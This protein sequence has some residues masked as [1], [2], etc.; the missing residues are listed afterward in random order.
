MSF[1][2]I[3]NI[4][5]PGVAGKPAGT[6]GE[7]KW[8]SLDRLM[9]DPRYQREVREQGKAHI[10]KIATSFDW[11]HFTPVIAAPITADSFAVIDGQH[12]LAAAKAIGLKEAPC[13]VVTAEETDQA[14][15]FM[16]INAMAARVSSGQLW[17]SRRM[18]GDPGAILAFEAA[19]EAGIEICRFPISGTYK[20]PSHCLAAVSILEAV[21]S[22]GH[23]IAV[24]ALKILRLAGEIR[25]GNFLQAKMIR[26]AALLCK[27]A[28]TKVPDEIAANAISKINVNTLFA[29][30]TSKA[31]QS[32]GKAVEHVVVALRSAVERGTR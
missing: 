21:R 26:A 24:R 20:K 28:W 11:K 29:D 22:Q 23:P 9:I 6:P 1:R 31:T 3:P 30:A 15:A 10:R 7:L 18:A 32:G 13:W 25:G 8:L 4:P 14:R 19:D 27:H 17:H 5:I 2:P 12:R 16:A